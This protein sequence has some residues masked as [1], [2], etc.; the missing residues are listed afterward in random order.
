MRNYHHPDLQVCALNTNYE[1]RNSNKNG[2]KKIRAYDYY[3][4]R[5]IKTTRQDLY[6]GEKITITR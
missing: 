3:E 4:L 6:V 1:I 2:K 5:T